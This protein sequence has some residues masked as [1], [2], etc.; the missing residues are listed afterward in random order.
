MQSIIE[1]TPEKNTYSNQIGKTKNE[2]VFI[3][4]EKSAAKKAILQSLLHPDY[5]LFDWEFFSNQLEFE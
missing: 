1:Q 4:K 5:V 2:N 3:L